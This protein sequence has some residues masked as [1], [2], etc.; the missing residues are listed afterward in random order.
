MKL[1]RSLVYILHV[2]PCN[3]KGVVIEA[4]TQE[5]R[6][7]L[8]LNTYV[9]KKSKLNV[10]PFVPLSI[11]AT[12]STELLNI[13]NLEASQNTW[14]LP[15]YPLKGQSLICAMYMN[16]LIWHLLKRNDPLPELFNLYEQVLFSLTQRENEKKLDWVLR[17]FEIKFLYLLGHHLFPSDLHKILIQTH[18]YY[19]FDAHGHQEL[20]DLGPA[21]NNSQA[22]S[23]ISG[24]FL[25]KLSHFLDHQSA[26]EEIRAASINADLEFRQASKLWLR[27][28]LHHILNG[29]TLR[30]RAYLQ[31][32]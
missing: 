26:L 13:K 10:Q 21:T 1:D 14:G 27:T 29:K 24:H 9:Q 28:V 31:T 15:Y 20:L 16:E 4:L 32:S 25:L 11:T 17:V 2:I 19:Q 30:A 23:S 3:E 5:S 12:G 6:V 8:F 18:H 22:A 7:G